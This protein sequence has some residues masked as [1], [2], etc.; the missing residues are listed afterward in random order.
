MP[1]GCEE[2]FGVSV[3]GFDSTISVESISTVGNTITLVLDSVPTGEVEINSHTASDPD[4]T[5]MPR[6]DLTY[7]GVGVAVEPLF[8]AIESS[9][10]STLT[11]T[12]TGIPDGS[13]SFEIW[14][15]S[16]S[17]MIRVSVEN[18]TFS[19]GTAALQVPL[20]NGTLV[21]SICD[22][23]NPPVTGVLCYG[24]TQ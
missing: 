19:S 9:S 7:G 5:K 24:V 6:G 1:V 23:N 13:Y 20:N 15:A 11:L 16:Q 3:D 4:H 22:G 21:K 10:D 12:A 18:I 14:D 2:C 17:P 8:V